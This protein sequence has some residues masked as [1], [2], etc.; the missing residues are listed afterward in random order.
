VHQSVVLSHDAVGHGQAQAGAALIGRWFG[1]EEGLEHSFDHF[2]RHSD[3]RVRNADAG[4]FSG[5][6][7]GMGRDVRVVERDV[8][9]GDGQA[10]TVRHGLMRVQA[11]VHEHLVQLRFVARNRGQV[12]ALHELEGDAFPEQPPHEPEQ[13]SQELVHVGGRSRQAL[14]TAHRQ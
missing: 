1:G 8:L 6:G 10:A 5:L 13:G 12:D 14:D 11:Q 9:R 7:P 2:L 4:V 3:A